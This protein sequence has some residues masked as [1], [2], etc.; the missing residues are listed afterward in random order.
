M[1]SQQIAKAY[2][3]I[4]ISEK[5]DPGD[6]G[7]PAEFYDIYPLI[8]K[9]VVYINEDNPNGCLGLQL[10]YNIQHIVGNTITTETASSNNYHIRFKTNVSSTYYYLSYNTLSPSYTNASFLTNY[11]NATNKPEYIIVE[12]C[13]GSSHTLVKQKIVPVVFNTGLLFDI[14]EELNT[15]TS[16]V[17]GLENQMDNLNVGSRNYARNTSDEWSDWITLRNVSN[18][19]E[20]LCSS[21]Y[22]PAEKNV[23]DFYT[24]QIT[25]QWS[26]VEA[27]Q[28]G[29]F[30]IAAQ[31]SV[32]GS[33]TTPSIWNTSLLLYRTEPEDSIVKYVHT[34]QIQES[35]KN[36]VEI[37]PSIRFD[38]ATGQFRYKCVQIEKG[39]IATDWRP[40]PEDIDSSIMSVSNSVSQIQQTMNTISSTVN[41]H[42]TNIN[43]INGQISSLNNDITRIEQKADGITST[44]DKLLVET[45]YDTQIYGGTFFTQSD[46]QSSQSISY[47]SSSNTYKMQCTSTAHDID[48]SNNWNSTTYRI[49]KGKY[50]IS[51]NIDMSVSTVQYYCVVSIRN[52]SGTLLS[53]KY[54]V[55]NSYS[56]YTKGTLVVDSFEVPQDN[57]RFH[58]YFESAYNDKQSSSTWWITVKDLKI[59]MQT[60]A[61]SILE[62]KADSI[63]STVF[64]QSRT[65]DSLKNDS[66]NLFKTTVYDGSELSAGNKWEFV[67]GGLNY[68]F[69]NWT[70]YNTVFVDG[71][72]DWKTE[73]TGT[74]YIYSPY[75]Y[76]YKDQAYTLNCYYNFE[77]CNNTLQ[78]CRYSNINNAKAIETI[79]ATTTIK[80]APIYME[81]QEDVVVFTPTTSAYY[82]IRFGNQVTNYDS[83]EDYIAE[84]GYVRLY[85]GTYTANQFSPWQSN[86]SQTYSKILQTGNSI[87]LKVH[88]ELYDT[89]I[90]IENQKVTL[91]ADNFIVN[92]NSNETVLGTDRDGNIEI[93][94]TIRAKSLY[95]EICF[96]VDGG[97]YHFPNDSDNKKW[98]YCSSLSEMIDNDELEGWGDHN[99]F[100]V[101]G[102]YSW[103]TDKAPHYGSPPNGFS[104]CTYDADIIMM[105]P[106]ANATWRYSTPVILPLPTDFPGKIIKIL[107]TR[108][109]TSVDSGASIKVGCVQSQKMALGFYASTTGTSYSAVSIVD[110]ITLSPYYNIELM[111]IDSKWIVMDISSKN[112]NIT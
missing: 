38:Y 98:Y 39:N 33:W 107:T 89:G 83:E 8:E 11:H 111:S 19:T 92:N 95:R 55:D 82:R 93:K 99:N 94:G 24:S 75:L 21:T 62:Q 101:G 88:Q 52:S 56:P 81:Y 108:S 97:I 70:K 27:S 2:Y 102:Y 14:N 106:K 28:D 3:T 69:D 47:N 84:L 68:T 80:T 63:S 96:F 32:D 22:L 67:A 86:N 61:A 30:Y 103:P 7:Q 4:Y 42:T 51:F 46:G 6:P 110:T 112:Y 23:G 35:N 87:S 53:E 1:I 26:S 76:L 85:R 45:L 17:Q 50:Q 91:T 79:A 10:Q 12:L 59:T 65:I 109:V 43:T 74:T 48:Y 20:R 54:V 41:T 13:N 49:D 64:E 40:A 60:Q 57:C 73:A 34:Y 36:Y 25:I 18:Q 29:T 16:T 72:G 44:V 90:D 58:L 66:K 9:C 105:L 15:I 71:Y 78:L 31:T 5:G 104:A 100:S 37:R 77:G